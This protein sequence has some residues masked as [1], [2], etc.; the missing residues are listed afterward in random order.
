MQR[1]GRTLI[2]FSRTPV[3]TTTQRSIGT[4]GLIS[5]QQSSESALRSSRRY[6]SAKQEE[7]IVREVGEIPEKK[8]AV[9]QTTEVPKEEEVTKPVPE[10]LE[11]TETVVGESK[12]LEFQAETRK[13]LDIVAKSLYTDKEIFVRELVSNSS[14]ALEKF[15]HA[16]VAGKPL[17]DTY[18][19]PEV[20]IHTD[21]EANTLII[22]DFGI[23]MTPEELVSNLGTI[24]KSGTLEYVKNSGDVQNLIGQFGVGFYSVFMVSDEVSVFSRYAVEGHKGFLWK[25][26]GSGTYQLAEAENVTRGTKIVMKLKES[27]REFSDGQVVKNI[28]TKHSNFVNFPIKLNGDRVNTIGAIWTKA[29]KD[30]TDEEHNHFYKFI[31]GLYEKHRM[32]LHFHTDSPM[33]LKALLYVPREHTEKYGLG[34]MEP[35][36][37]L[38]C[39]KVLIQ[40]NM[41]NLLPNYFR[42]IKGVV[43]C[44]DIPLNLSREHLQDSQLVSRLSG[45]LARRLIKFLAD[46]AKRDKEGYEAFFREFGKFIREGVA[47]ESADREALGKLLRYESSKFGALE[48]VSLDEYVDR[49]PEDQEEIYYATGANRAMTEGSP[50]MEHFKKH[51]LEVIYCYDG[52][53]EWVMSS[54]G[55]FRGKKIKGVESVEIKAEEEELSEEARERQ[56][57]FNNWIR[58]VLSDKVSNVKDT[59]RL[60]DSPAVVVDHE[61]LAFRRMVMQMDPMNAPKL[62]KQTLEINAKHPIMKGL[63]VIRETNEPL[64]TKIIEQVFDNA[65]MTAGLLSDSRPMVSRINEILVETLNKEAPQ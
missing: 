59:A 11:Q 7:P 20:H 33:N 23:G 49:M 25:S 2:R 42:F 48:M 62:P 8:E 36:V 6:Y 57:A 32:N 24:A 4:K 19:Q 61:S 65:L 9:D 13:L 45:V 47:T 12:T 37:S 29:K 64:A 54:L 3:Q 60:T 63:S 38:Y 58:D 41:K 44:E 40:S 28:L 43:D 51:N 26:D 14:D 1:V 22:Q 18:I 34:Q 46:E 15:R 17:I 16:E 53:D 30:I 27:C 52:L 5:F 31:T 56:K 21:P 35:G 50:Y 10:T 55:S 39:R